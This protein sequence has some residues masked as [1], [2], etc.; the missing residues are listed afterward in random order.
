MLEND[1]ISTDIAPETTE[2]TPDQAESGADVTGEETGETPAEK[3]AFQPNFKF[4]AYDKDGE[5]EEWARP[6]IQDKETEDRFRQLYAKSAGFDTLKEKYKSK[7]DEASEWK[8]KHTQLESSV[9]DHDKAWEELRYY[10]DNDIG[11]FLQTCKISDDQ[12][13]QY[14]E[15]RMEYLKLPE[16][17]R[18]KLDERTEAAHRAWQLEGQL[19][20]R[21]QRDQH[22]QVETH[23]QE[24]RGY[25]EHPEISTFAGRYDQVAGEPGAFEKAVVQHG[26]AH[27]RRTGETLKPL[28]A[29]RAVYK[30]VK[31]FL[32]QTSQ[33]AQ[34]AQ[35]QQRSQE[36]SP[37][38]EAGAPAR[39]KKVV[40]NITGASAVSPSRKAFKS[41]D[42]LKNYAKQMASE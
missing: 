20:E 41:I 39:P 33:P 21:D 32:G 11:R 38:Q 7:L 27:F 25:M 8:G 17:K 35:Q 1:Q 12:L 14:L 30:Q 2:T 9:K 19:K 10:R 18:A 24:F 22:S 26:D 34:A 3:P 4:K 6:L 13:V 23:V 28:D 31:P 29:I 5:I 42:D 15:D 36:T 40:P 16:N 37:G